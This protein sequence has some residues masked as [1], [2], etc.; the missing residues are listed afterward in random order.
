MNSCY[1][2]TTLDHS[3]KSDQGFMGTTHAL[4]AVAIFFSLVAF[5]PAKFYSVLGANNVWVV[6]LAAAVTA[7]ASLLPDLDNTRSTSKS[8]LGYL[9]DALSLLFRS[10]SAVIQTF[11]RT[12]RDSPDPNPHRGFYHT[13][14]AA[15]LLGFLTYL[16]TSIKGGNFSVPFIGVVT[17]G[18]LF[19]LIITWLCIHMALAGLAKS[20]V[21]KMKSKAGVFG[22]LVP[23]VFSFALTFTIFTQIPKGID[24]WW[25][26]VSVALGCFI[27]LFGD[28][29]TTA[30]NP[31]LF[32][33]PY[34]G[35]M[36]W[37]VRFTKIKSGGILEQYVFIP[38]F[39]VMCL[40]SFLKISGAF[41]LMG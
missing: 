38:F 20:F 1:L 32:P 24:F 29:F 10:S 22:E 28:C 23:F 30:G 40:V 18:T 6:I 33:I 3:K 15:L 11:V 36:W 41:G 31:I 17:Y 4:S 13:I 26:G 16:A 9:G 25:L 37:T 35:K 34:K 8:S 12:S 5:F 21:R 7:G 39:A 14:P 27:H 2:N 19:A